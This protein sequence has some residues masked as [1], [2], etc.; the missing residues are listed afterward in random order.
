[1]PFLPILQI[2]VM[3][4][5]FYLILIHTEGAK[6]V[7]REI[8]KSQSSYFTLLVLISEVIYKTGPAAKQFVELKVACCVTG[9]RSLE[10]IGKDEMVSTTVKVVY[11]KLGLDKDQANIP[12]REVWWKYIFTLTR[13]DC[14]FLSYVAHDWFFKLLRTFDLWD[15]ICKKK[16]DIKLLKYFSMKQN[17]FI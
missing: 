17:V 11:W 4:L 16:I 9:S 12:Y 1:M 7:H 2:L 14:N 13:K 5:S 6:K 10:S 15:A 8:T 3:C